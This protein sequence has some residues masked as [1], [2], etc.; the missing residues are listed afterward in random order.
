M[1]EDKTSNNDGIECSS[2]WSSYGKIDKS[3]EKNLAKILA[4]DCLSW[5]YASNPDINNVVLLVVITETTTGKRMELKSLSFDLPFS[6][7]TRNSK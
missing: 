7:S 4:L 6:N 1:V 2:I 3:R 5:Y